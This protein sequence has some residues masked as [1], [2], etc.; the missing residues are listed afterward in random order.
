M[1]YKPTQTDVRTFFCNTYAK[2]R[3]RKAQTM[4]ALEVLANAWMD[5]H[6][7]YHVDFSDLSTALQKTN[8]Q[9]NMDFG[10]NPFL[11][12][13]MHLS[14]SEQCSIDQ[15]KGIRLAVEQLTS[16]LNSLH[17]AHHIAIEYLA[18][19]IADSQANGTPL[20][21]HSYVEAVSRRATKY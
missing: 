19:M 9:E 14:L 20:D 12:L 1:L 7:E 6:P 4:E 5:E 10:R 3:Q 8:I 11:H 18:Q 13:S 15:P 16:R 21:G 17:D 2:A